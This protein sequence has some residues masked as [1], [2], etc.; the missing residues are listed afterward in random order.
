MCLNTRY[1]FI[2]TKQWRSNAS[3]QTF[4][5]VKNK[6]GKLKQTHNNLI[7]IKM[8]FRGVKYQPIPIVITVAGQ[9]V[10]CNNITTDRNY[11]KVNGIQA[12]T[13]DFIAMRSLTSEKFEIN[14]QEIY[15]QGWDVQLISSGNDLNP[16]ERFDNEIDEPAD[17]ST[18]NISLKDGSVGGQVYPYTVKV[19]LRLVNPIS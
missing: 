14:G 12:Y 6:R 5:K 18:V 4:L 13:D 15:P 17:G 8:I 3:L 11:K 16:N 2:R 10:S 19:V 9:T 1:F 7:F